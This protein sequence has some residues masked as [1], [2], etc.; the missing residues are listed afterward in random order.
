[1]ETREEVTHSQVRTAQVQMLCPGP[2]FAL[3]CRERG[4]NSPAAAP[5]HPRDRREATV[6]LQWGPRS[7]RCRTVASG[8]QADP[9]PCCLFHWLR[10]HHLPRL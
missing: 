4:S 5:H 6:R 2:R 10:L 3:G 7:D 9:S 1:M 8:P